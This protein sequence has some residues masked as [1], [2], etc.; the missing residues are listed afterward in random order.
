MRGCDR[1]VWQRV[2]C[3]VV[4]AT[5]LMVGCRDGKA[6]VSID[7]ATD[8]VDVH[9]RP[10]AQVEHIDSGTAE[11]KPPLADGGFDSDT[12]DSQEVGCVREGQP[13]APFSAIN[14]CCP[15]LVP[16]RAGRPIPG[17][18][19]FDC[20]RGIDGRVC[21]NC[22]NGICED[23]ELPCGCPQDCQVDGGAVQCGPM[24][25]HETEYCVIQLSGVDSGAPTY[26]CVETAVDCPD[27][28]FSCRC[29]RAKACPIGC[30]PLRRK[31]TCTGV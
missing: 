2:C 22:G 13:S 30:D 24:V 10:D 27:Q 17:F 26:T 3:C 9:D 15:G 25:C 20:M 28:V 6:V 11:D 29:S 12:G 1:C 23:W 14:D 4:L 18:P 7:A 5:A 19:P 16:I 21:S 31:V 8:A